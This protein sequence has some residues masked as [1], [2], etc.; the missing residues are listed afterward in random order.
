MLL[1]RP[2]FGWVKLY[3]QQVKSFLDKLVVEIQERT[4]NEGS[5]LYFLVKKGYPVQR[6]QM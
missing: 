2:P 3:R 1:T 5:K 4:E 6:I